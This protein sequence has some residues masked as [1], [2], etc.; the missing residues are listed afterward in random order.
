MIKKMKNIEMVQKVNS[1]MEF[2][3]K[4]KEVPVKLSCA[5]AANIKTLLSELEIYEQERKKI[6]ENDLGDERFKELCD[7]ETDIN[8]RSVSQNVVEGL[9]IST[10]DYMA[11]EFMIE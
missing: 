1:L 4:D 11:L 3:K 6:I 10:K 2:V 8:I 7:V 9:A 5:I